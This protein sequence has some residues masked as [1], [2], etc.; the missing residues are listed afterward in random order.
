MSTILRAGFANFWYSLCLVS[1]T[2]NFHSNFEI[3]N[4][5]LFYHTSI[6][7]FVAFYRKKFWP[8]P[9][10]GTNNPLP[11]GPIETP[12]NSVLFKVPLVRQGQIQE[13]P[14]FQNPSSIVKQKCRQNPM[15][16]KT[17]LDKFG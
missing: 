7:L 17:I 2:C 15:K 1:S 12:K 14:T 13:L 4:Q 11:D 5:W 10:H 8:A 6:S 9:L 3:S 16:K